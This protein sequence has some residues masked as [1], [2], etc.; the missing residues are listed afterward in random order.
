MLPVL[1]CYIFRDSRS[2]PGLCSTSG[3]LGATSG[4]P[5][6]GVRVLCL[7]DEGSLATLALQVLFAA[8]QRVL[9]ILVP[10][11]GKGLFSSLCSSL[12]TLQ[13]YSSHT[14]SVVLSSRAQLKVRGEG[15]RLVTKRG[16]D[17][18]TRLSWK[19][20]LLRAVSRSVRVEP[21]SAGAGSPTTSNLWQKP[22]C[23]RVVSACHCLLREP[24]LCTWV[25]WLHALIRPSSPV[26]WAPRG[27]VRILPATSSTTEVTTCTVRNSW[28][29]SEVWGRTWDQDCQLSHLAKWGL[30]CMHQRDKIL[31]V[32]V[33]ETVGLF[34][35]RSQATRRSFVPGGRAMYFTV[36]GWLVH[37]CF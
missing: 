1:L 11:P 24:G 15:T 23:W 20:C 25:C 34:V 13:T 29:F 5:F 33:V 30:T 21:A 18:L 8:G 32:S 22:S 6:D 12:G 2:L 26:F 7:H 16:N 28:L 4:R 17:G 10:G 19:G 37:A 3:V 31:Q 14:S 9:P 36:T 27:Q 35:A